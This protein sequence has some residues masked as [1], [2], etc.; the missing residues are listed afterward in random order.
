MEEL[1][2]Q[3]TFIRYTFAIMTA[4]VSLIFLISFL[5]NLYSLKSQQFNTFYAKSEQV[6]HTLENNQRELS[7][8]Q[9]NLD[10]DYLTRARAAEYVFDH[11]EETTKDV[12]EMQ[13]LANLLDVDELHIIDENGIIVSGSVSKYIGIDMADHKQTSP[14]LDLLESNDENA[15]L[16]QEAQPNA[17][18]DKIMQYVGVVRKGTKGVVQVGFKPTRQIEVQSRNTYEYIFS[19][20]PTDA[21]EELFA[22]DRTTGAIVGHSNGMTN[23][24]QEECYQLDQLSDCTKGAYKKGKDGQ[25]MYV[26][27][28]EYSDILICA[29]LP[30]N[31][32]LQKLWNQVFSTLLYLLVIEAIVLLLLNYLVKK[33]TVEGI[34]HIME[35]LSAITHG[36][37]DTTVSVGGNREFEALS[38]GINTMVKSIVNSSN[39]ISAIIEISGIPLA[40][41]EYERGLNHVFSTSRLKELLDI[42]DQ[43]A[44][45]FYNNSV[46]FDRYIREI[47]AEPL[48]GESD[49][50]RIRESKYVRIHMSESSGKYLGVVT[51][52]SEDILKKKQIIYENT[53]D[54]LTKLYK[55]THFKQLAKETLEHILPG[56]LCAIAMLDLDSFKSINDTFG[57]DSGD[58]YLQKF[59]SILQSMPSEHFLTARRSGDEFCMMIFNCSSKAEIQG[60]LNFF[61]ETLEADQIELAPA[62]FRTIR[63]S[64]G[65]VCS[66]D[67]KDSIDKLLSQADQALY[68]I[69]RQTKGCYGEYCG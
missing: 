18:E 46:L 55:F 60:Y 8:M 52:V 48:P 31:T 10:K 65:F 43:M 57:H 3:K 36:N 16:I 59:S 24:F 67:A 45:R 42:P 54:S 41:F 25:T 40:A 63:A 34:H 7:I 26:F 22:V 11:Q 13:Y 39:R 61:Y 20:F 23:D 15:F 58:K 64:C 51:D 9:E 66:A 21:G 29:A 27:S 2:M 28:R 19:K 44:E 47:M 68:D 32:L 62:E 14:F 50:F 35:S 4:A 30:L 33:K 69:K 53:H 38:Q 56:N 5:F 12:E 37:L 17:A 49:I 1:Y 6:I